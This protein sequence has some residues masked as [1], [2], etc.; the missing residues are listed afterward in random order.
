MEHHEVQN[1][2]RRHPIYLVCHDWRDP[3]NVGAAFRLADAAGLS[4]LMLTGTTP[5]PPNNKIN[6]TARSTV[7][8]VPYDSPENP[9]DFLNEQR[10][11][12]ALILALEITNSSKSLLDYQLP[13]AVIDDNR[14]AFLI[15]GAEANGVPAALLSLCDEALHLP[16]FGQNTS[17]NVAVA[18]GAAVYL[19]VAQFK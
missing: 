11:A 4:G 17:M 18:M 3:L 9:V 10:A 7:R 1:T 16:M 13:T 14:P 12:G 2:N 5:V 8:S 19:L 6:K 15:A